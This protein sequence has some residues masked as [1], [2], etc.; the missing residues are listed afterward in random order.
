M[1]Q[2]K[3]HICTTEVKQKHP[4][5]FMMKR[6]ELGSRSSSTLILPVNGCV[7]LYGCVWGGVFTGVYSGQCGIQSVIGG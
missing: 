3:E 2:R 5:L 7:F 1:F 4:N 6:K